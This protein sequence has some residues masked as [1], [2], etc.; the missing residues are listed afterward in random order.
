MQSRLE[1]ISAEIRRGAQLP[2]DGFTIE[3]TSTP[4][5]SLYRNEG[6]ADG[7]LR[8]KTVLPRDDAVARLAELGVDEPEQAVDAAHAPDL[9][10]HREPGPEAPARLGGKLNA[11][12]GHGS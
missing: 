3:R 5:G 4:D 11:G 9:A 1:L 10:R 8:F 6:W 7:L 2:M 12:C